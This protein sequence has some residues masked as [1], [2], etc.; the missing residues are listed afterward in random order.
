VGFPQVQQ[1]AR[2]PRHLRRAW[3]DRHAPPKCW[4]WWRTRCARDWPAPNG[5]LPVARPGV[6][7]AACTRGWGAHREDLCRVRRPIRGG[8]PGPQDPFV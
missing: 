8:Q 3:R 7:K 2:L 5:W 4:P 1:V 6:L